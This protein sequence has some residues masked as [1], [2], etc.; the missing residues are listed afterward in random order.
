MHDKA[1]TYEYII[2][3]KV[4]GWKFSIFGGASRQG[5]ISRNNMSESDQIN[6][7]WNSWGNVRL[8]LALTI[9]LVMSVP[10]EWSNGGVQINLEQS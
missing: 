6:V 2:D 10:G 1:F 4:Y 3:N 9:N 8:T 7:Y 5:F